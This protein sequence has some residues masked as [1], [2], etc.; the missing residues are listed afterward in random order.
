MCL[1]GER[2]EGHLSLCTDRRGCVRGSASEG[3]GGGPW[4]GAAGYSCSSCMA[5]KQL[6][7]GLSFTSAFIALPTQP[8]EP[9]TDRG[10]GQ[11]L[12]ITHTTTDSSTQM[13]E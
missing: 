10:R 12:S 11:S 9:Q 7:E 13:K 1:W 8:E 5:V 4:R 3:G 2:L 6:C